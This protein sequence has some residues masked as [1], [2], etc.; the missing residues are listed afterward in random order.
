MFQIFLLLLQ[1]WLNYFKTKLNLIQKTF[2]ELS[3]TPV[4]E[5]VIISKLVGVL[6]NPELI[7]EK[8]VLNNHF[9]LEKD[10]LRPFTLK[11]KVKPMWLSVLIEL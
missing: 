3:L 5:V 2:L 1:K 9:R 4:S 6:T 10:I 7:P 11:F 8:S